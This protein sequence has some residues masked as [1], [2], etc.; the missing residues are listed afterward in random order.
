MKPRGCRRSERRIRG[1]LPAPFSLVIDATPSPASSRQ[2][3]RERCD[4]RVERDGSRRRHALADQPS[5]RLG[6][7]DSRPWRRSPAGRGRS[8]GGSVT[9]TT[10]IRVAVHDT[11]GG[12]HASDLD[13]MFS[14]FFTTE[15]GGM[16][17]TGRLSSPRRAAVDDS[18]PA[19]RSDLPTLA[20]G[21]LSRVARDGTLTAAC[22]RAAEN[23]REC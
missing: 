19:A 15:P 8:F 20:A 23:S 4:V 22:P 12:V 18:Q 17:G 7:T 2:K 16:P 21:R 6:V 1:Q 9:I 14:A 11:G 13:R 5:N 3:D 10:L